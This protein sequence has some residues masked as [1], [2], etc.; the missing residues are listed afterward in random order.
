VQKV[1]KSGKPACEKC[2]RRLSTCKGKLYKRSPGYICQHC[3]NKEH[4]PPS[5]AAARAAAAAAAADDPEVTPAPKRRRTLSDPG[6]LI[7]VTPTVKLSALLEWGR[8]LYSST[9]STKSL[10][11]A[12]VEIGAEVK[13]HQWTGISGSVK[14]W[15]M[16]EALECSR[17]DQI[18]ISA[19]ASLTSIARCYLR[20]AGVSTDDLVCSDIALMLM[21]QG[22]GEQVPHFDVQTYED[23]CRCWIILLYCTGGRATAVPDSNLADL[24]ETFAD[25]EMTPPP[26]ARALIRENR[27]HA[28]E[29]QSGAFMLMNAA[30][31]HKAVKHLLPS[32]RFTAFA[33]FH[34]KGKWVNCRLSRFPNG[35][36]KGHYS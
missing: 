12:M 23:A 13:A 19:C 6:E 25:G 21:H 24:R 28:S 5:A 9:R 16:H 22:E 11:A 14:E 26:R 30:L 2:E 8:E 27:F 10:A 20:Q 15:W 29:V 4:R 34:P 36:P 32:R 35:V 7:E 3:H 1:D 31:P 17:V 33:F 18:R